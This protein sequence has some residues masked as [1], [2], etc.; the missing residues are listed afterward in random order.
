MTNT[1]GRSS[2][3][4]FGPMVLLLFASGA[5]ANTITSVGGVPPPGPPFVPPSGAT[6]EFE[7]I[8]SGPNISGDAFLGATDNGSG[9]F[10]VTSIT[11]T[12]TLGGVSQNITGLIAPTSTPYS[13]YTLQTYTNPICANFGVSSPCAYVYLYNDLIYPTGNPLLDFYGLLF[14]VN[15][16]A[17]PVNICGQFGCSNATQYGE[18]T[19]TSGQP[20]FGTNYDIASLT[21]KQVPE[22]S[23][24]VLLGAGLVL[25][26]LLARRKSGRSEQPL[27]AIGSA[28]ISS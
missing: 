7:L 4:V 25:V 11:G 2:L 19:F 1:V 6:A 28:T 22:P 8:Y 3:L 26:M 15:G 12:Q 17:S 21:L 23:T 24:V 10:T 16:E 5:Y 27:D 9:S 14:T 18:T 13:T 20:G